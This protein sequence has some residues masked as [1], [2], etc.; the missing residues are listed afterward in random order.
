MPKETR[1]GRTAK[2]VSN[3]YELIDRIRGLMGSVEPGDRIENWRK[4]MMPERFGDKTLSE[5]VERGRGAD[6]RPVRGGGMVEAPSS[7]CARKMGRRVARTRTVRFGEEGGDKGGNR[8][9]A[10]GAER[11]VHRH[12]K[13]TTSLKDR[14][15][16][17]LHT[18]DADNKFSTAS[19][20][21]ITMVNLQYY[22][23]NLTMHDGPKES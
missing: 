23:E 3:P 13:W 17:D 19:R 5:Q 1:K 12:K 7:P 16:T 4:Q 20:R 15:I 8:M 9:G 6:R 11:R 14:S 18:H 21:D 2:R 10:E 22:L